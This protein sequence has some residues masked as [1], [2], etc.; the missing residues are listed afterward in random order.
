[1][2]S[3]TKLLLL[4][5]ILALAVNVSAQD[6][7]NQPPGCENLCG[8]TFVQ[9]GGAQDFIGDDPATTSFDESLD[10]ETCDQGCLQGEPYDCSDDL[11]NVGTCSN[12]CKKMEC[13][14]GITQEHLGE[15]CDGGGTCGGNPIGAV[16]T[17]LNAESVC[18]AGVLCIPVDGDGCTA[19][20]KEDLDNDGVDDSEDNCNPSIANL[21]DPLFA[22]NIDNCKNGA[23]DPN[24]CASPFESNCNQADDLDVPPTEGDDVGNVCDLCPGT[25][26]ND[27]EDPTTFNPRSG[28]KVSQIDE[29][30]DGICFGEDLL[31]NPVL[32]KM[33]RVD[34][35]NILCSVVGSEEEQDNCPAIANGAF[36]VTCA[37][38]DPAKAL[39]ECN[40]INTDFDLENGDFLGDP[41]DPDDDGDL[42]CDGPFPDPTCPGGVLDNCPKVV[43]KD[44][45]N[46]DLN[47]FFCPSCTKFDDLG[48]A[49]D[50]DDDND[51]I[52]DLAETATGCTPSQTNKKDNCPKTA[53]PGQEITEG[54]VFGDACPQRT[55]PVDQGSVQVEGD[56]TVEQPDSDTWEISEHTFF[57]NIDLPDGTVTTVEEIGDLRNVIKVDTNDMGDST[58]SSLT[59]VVRSTSESELKGATIITGLTGDDVVTL[60]VQKIAGTDQI[61]V[62]EDATTVN[63]LCDGPTDTRVLC[64]GTA[65][66]YTCE[67]VGDQYKVFLVA[68][69]AVGEVFPDTD[70]DGFPDD[71]DDCP[72]ETGS[73]NGCPAVCGN[74]IA[75]S[76]EIC[77]GTDLAGETCVSQGF[78]SGIL[79][80]A[81][82]CDAFDT[83]ACVADTDGDGVV[84]VNDLCLGTAAGVPVDSVGCS[85]AQVDGDGDGVCNPDS[86]SVSI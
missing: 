39:F 49:C 77:D 34:G 51:G 73:E 2:K 4:I 8:D 44:Q 22:G 84:G 21:C 53:N 15:T 80:C 58:F 32:M 65:G 3:I 33:A 70:G 79:A 40:Q 86:P 16:C 75:G 50:P 81:V 45:K 1:M 42:I 60:F 43:N 20:C 46:N 6:A 57:I 62:S 31:G 19:L 30:A 48:D 72:A 11:N 27:L 7:P 66:G 82:T 37:E 85:D 24:T 17:T 47:S 13:G 67:D 25:I 35:E 23:F 71:E 83:S 36:G 64:P 9:L 5:M 29:D 18:G 54:N 12:T 69:A 68:N 63:K 28:C 41:C 78:E 14:D 61:C 56:A 59:T 38:T 74:N 52:C 55:I 10:D 76:L 26:T